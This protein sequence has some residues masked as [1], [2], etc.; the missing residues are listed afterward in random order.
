MMEEY[1]LSCPTI[2]MFCK[3]WFIMKMLGVDDRVVR[4]ALQNKDINPCP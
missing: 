3:S 1:I 4:E 2:S